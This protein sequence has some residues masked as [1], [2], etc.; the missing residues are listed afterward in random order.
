MSESLYPTLSKSNDK[1]QEKAS[2]SEEDLALVNALKEF[3]HGG[4]KLHG[5]SD[6]SAS[7]Y[8]VLPSQAARS[9]V[10]PA[11]LKENLK[12]AEGT[13]LVFG[14]I[15]EHIESDQ[16]LSSLKA[17]RIIAQEDSKTTGTSSSPVAEDVDPLE[18]EWWTVVPPNER[19]PTVS[20]PEMDRSDS[21]ASTT[22]SLD[23]SYV[24]VEE[25][26]VIAA[27]GE[28]IALYLAN[29]PATRDL[30]P[31]RLQRMLATSF[32]ELREKGAV[33]RL[34]DWGMFLYATYGWGV[35]GLNIYRDPAMVRWALKAVWT[36][37]KWMMLFVWA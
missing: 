26:D 21:G 4:S 28:F 15:Q 9:K 32:S 8:P 29:I 2:H 25:E 6:L 36:A 31:E 23:G 5:R 18:T 13:R 1:P 19:D 20:S 27:I 14:Q 3:R 10:T 37:C 7:A 17:S 12:T 11:Q 16:F 24:L 22:S 35:T 33:R 30:P 34:W